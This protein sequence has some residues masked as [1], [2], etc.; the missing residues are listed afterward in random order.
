GWSARDDWLRGEGMFDAGRYPVMR[1]RSTELVFVQG[2]LVAAAGLL[3][4]RDVT[5]RV[6]FRVER[7]Q[8]APAPGG[9][10]ESCAA[11]G[12]STIRRSDFGM[13]TA[14]GLVSDDVELSFRVAASRP[15]H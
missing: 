8:C 13:T 9:G 1:F 5:R 7:F 10:R 3:T 4:L 14:L 12:I 6:S 15:R 2:R 11:D